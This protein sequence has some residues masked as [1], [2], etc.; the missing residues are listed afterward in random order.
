M[1]EE[2]IERRGEREFGATRLGCEWQ[3]V[4]MDKDSRDVALLEWEARQPEGI[5]GD[6]IWRLNCYREALFLVDRVRDDVRQLGGP[7][8]NKDVKEQLL[9][10]VGSIAANIGEGYGRLTAAD[11]TRFFS[12]ALGSIREAVAWYQALRP[13]EEHPGIEDRIVRLSR[14]RRMVLGLLGRL[15]ERKG[16]KFDAW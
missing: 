5:T 4:E 2:A 10:A 3:L 6:P 11:R 1:G 14:I 13:P 9:T 7:A 16:R 15:R 12:Y 8:E